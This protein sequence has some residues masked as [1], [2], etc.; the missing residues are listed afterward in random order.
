MVRFGM[1]VLTLIT[2]NGIPLCIAYVE[3][4]MDC[5]QQIY[6][7]AMLD[8]DLIANENFFFAAIFFLLFRLL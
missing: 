7:H 2:L 4:R 5:I 8:L 1:V 3:L 6:K